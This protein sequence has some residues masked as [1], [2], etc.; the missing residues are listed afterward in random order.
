MPLNPEVSDHALLVPPRLHIM[1][2]C[3]NLEREM[4]NAIHNSKRIEDVDT[5]GSD[6]ALDAARYG[7]RHAFQSRRGQGGARRYYFAN[8]RIKVRN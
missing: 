8:G 2:T 1:D 3:P 7:L 6:H 4:R 5:D